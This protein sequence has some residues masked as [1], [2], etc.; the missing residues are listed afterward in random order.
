MPA[1]PSPLEYC[2][3]IDSSIRR[4]FAFMPGRGFL[5]LGFAPSIRVNPV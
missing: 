2:I 5:L 1:D 3:D 4:R